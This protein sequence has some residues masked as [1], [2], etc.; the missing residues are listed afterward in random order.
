MK[1]GFGKVRPGDRLFLW[2]C[3]AELTW[4]QRTVEAE[5]PLEGH[6]AVRGTRGAPR[7]VAM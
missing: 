3:S 1:T 2:L 7:V 5:K 6:R 4:A